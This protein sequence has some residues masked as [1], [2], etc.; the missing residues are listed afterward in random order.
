MPQFAY[1]ARDDEG[2]L[3]GGLISARTMEEAGNLLSQRELFVTRIGADRYD[4]QA[5][6]G[7]AVPHEAGAA[8]HAQVAWC[9]L[10]LSIMVET[11]ICLSDALK[12]LARQASQPKLRSLLD[13]VSQTVEEGRSL[14]DA[15][16]M[17]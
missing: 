7:G 1:E 2:Q 17:Y 13:R 12:Y 14:S 8:S 9:M 6:A 15:M 4:A 3:T 10:Q 16:A 11:G 5:K